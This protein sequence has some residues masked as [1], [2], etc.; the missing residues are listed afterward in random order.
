MI[1]LRREAFEKLDDCSCGNWQEKTSAQAV[2]IFQRSCS[3]IALF[4]DCD[5]SPFL[6][7]GFDSA[8]AK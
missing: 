5:K 7:A 8:I 3:F 4:A 6:I 2:A 1:L